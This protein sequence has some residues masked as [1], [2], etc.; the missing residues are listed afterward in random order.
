MVKAKM[1]I[2]VMIME[3]MEALHLMVVRAK[4]FITMAEKAKV[5]KAKV[6]KAVWAKVVKAKAVITVVKAKVVK[7][8]VTKVVKARANLIIKML[9]HVQITLAKVKKEQIILFSMIWG[10]GQLK[11]LMERKVIRWTSV[12][13][14]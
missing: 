5:V 4:M 12:D 10:T 13:L 3:T 7:A 14:V 1:V 9:M 11:T 6:D 8:K 2:T